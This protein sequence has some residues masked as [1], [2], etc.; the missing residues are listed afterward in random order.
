[1]QYLGQG[2][3]TWRGPIES[4]GYLG[5]D[6]TIGWRRYVT[7]VARSVAASA[8][9]QCLAAIDTAKST[10]HFMTPLGRFLSLAWPRSL[11]A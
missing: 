5:E 9:S 6:A 7:A 8:N 3:A 11:G 10:D 2:A 4:A 1:V